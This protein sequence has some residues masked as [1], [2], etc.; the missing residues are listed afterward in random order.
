MRLRKLKSAESIQNFTVE[1]EIFLMTLYPVSLPWRLSGGAGKFITFYVSQCSQFQT[2]LPVGYHQCYRCA[3]TPC[4]WSLWDYIPEDSIHHN[5]L[6][7][8][9]IPAHVSIWSRN[10]IPEVK[11]DNDCNDFYRTSRKSEWLAVF[12]AP[13]SKMYIPLITLWYFGPSERVS[14]DVPL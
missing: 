11:V 12:Y 7:R 10:K 2:W 9:S 1:Y 5:H 6:V 3:N 14:L 4:N 13:H 8:T